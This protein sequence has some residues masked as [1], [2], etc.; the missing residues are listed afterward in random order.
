MNRG[1]L[2]MAKLLVK[3]G[4]KINLDDANDFSALGL[5]CSRGHAAITKF[6]IEAGAKVNE[7]NKKFGSTALHK[8]CNGGSVSCVNVLLKHG[9][10]IDM[11][12][13]K[14]WVF[15]FFHLLSF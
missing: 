9:A 13:N 4:A 6:L 10:Y 11:K 15:F 12:N 14:G 1:N 3:N 7:K 2:P 5:S 8:A